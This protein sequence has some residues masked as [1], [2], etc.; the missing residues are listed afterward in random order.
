MAWLQNTP[1]QRD[2]DTAAG[3]DDSV[4]MSSE[5]KGARKWISD[6]EKCFSFWVKLASDCTICMHACPFNRDFSKRRHKLWLSLAL[7]PLRQPV[8]RLDKTHSER[9]NTGEWWVQNAK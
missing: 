7:S 4:K 1:P 8:L 9:K 6:A 2:G 5:I 3:I